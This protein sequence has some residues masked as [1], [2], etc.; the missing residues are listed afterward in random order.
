M[1]MNAYKFYDTEKYLEMYNN[2]ED[3]TPSGKVNSMR[4]V[5]V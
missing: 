2:V 4:R 1:Q 3:S 5:N